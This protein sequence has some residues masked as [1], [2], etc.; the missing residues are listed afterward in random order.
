MKNSPLLI[1]F[2]GFACW[3][4]L[5]WRVA[6][7]ARMRE[8]VTEFR[9]GGFAGLVRKYGWKFVAGFVAFYLI[10]DVTLYLLM[11]WLA[12]KELFSP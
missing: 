9:A 10:R 5:M 2:L 7:I 8:A 1:T 11:P 12:A 3:A 6:S 4:A